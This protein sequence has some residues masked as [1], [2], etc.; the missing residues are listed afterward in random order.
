M[1]RGAAPSRLLRSVPLADSG[2]TNVDG[3]PASAVDL[4]KLFLT[5]LGF[6][7]P[8]P[9]AEGAPRDPSEARQSV[10][11]THP[12]RT[13]DDNS[14]TSLSSPGRRPRKQDKTMQNQACNH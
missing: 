7:V 9:T 13:D 1:A 14:G 2:R 4:L 12:P 3:K 6:E 10:T 11:G 8:S 5:D